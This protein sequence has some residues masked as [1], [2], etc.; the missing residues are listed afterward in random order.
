[1]SAQS[2]RW[3]DKLERRLSWIAIP[4]IGLLFIT[5]QALGFLMVMSD[6]IWAMRLMLL[7]SAVMQGEVWRLVTFLA[8]PVNTQPIWIIFSLWFLYFIFDTLENLWGSFKLTFYVLISILL[9]IAVSFSLGY[10]VTEVSD[11]ESTLFLAAATLFPDFEVRLFLAIPVKMKW[12]AWISVLFLFIRL[13]QTDLAGKI[14]I[15][16]VYSNYLVFFGPSLIETL[17]QSARRRA[18]RRKLRG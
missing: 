5:L 7:P 17:R 10:P 3:L 6:P 4:K 12:L 9:T 15:V 14:L 1:M 11:F 18:Y 16:A 2:P 13:F 8:L